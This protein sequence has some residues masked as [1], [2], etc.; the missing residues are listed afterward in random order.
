MRPAEGTSD[1]REE[2]HR[3]RHVSS[4]PWPA[5]STRVGRMPVKR[6]RTVQRE[7]QTNGQTD[8][9]DDERKSSLVA[10]RS[11]SAKNPWSESGCVSPCENDEPRRR[12]RV[13]SFPFVVRSVRSFVC[14]P[15]P[16]SLCFRPLRC[17]VPRPRSVRPKKSALASERGQTRT[18][19]RREI[20]VD[21][22]S[23]L[24]KRA[25]VL[26]RRRGIAALV[27][28]DGEVVVGA[29]AAGIDCERTVQQ[30]ACVGGAA[31]RAL[32]E[33]EIDQRLDVAAID[34]QRNPELG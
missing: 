4:H 10:S 27:R 20:R 13:N 19:L 1:L 26:N 16:P 12:Y 34:A 9:T 24:Q 21:D 33:R 28:D 17:S 3:T 7:R 29:G 5:D 31:L 14:L 32:N 11:S 6:Q 18:D 25:V 2:D 22:G 30:V 15:F 8:R 23:E